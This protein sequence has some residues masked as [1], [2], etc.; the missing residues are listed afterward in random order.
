MSKEKAM[1]TRDGMGAVC[2]DDVLLER[3][4]AHVEGYE[5][6]GW[7][8]MPG[9]ESGLHMLLHSD[10]PKATQERLCL[11]MDKWAHETGR[12]PTP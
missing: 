9:M 8:T 7:G 6:R 3:L 5:N 10:L 4:Q 12:W 2:A 11:A 1:A